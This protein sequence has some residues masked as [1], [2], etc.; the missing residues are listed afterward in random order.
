MTRVLV[1]GFD[2]FGGET[3]NPAWEAVDLLRN[4][5]YAGCRGGG[6]EIPGRVLD[7]HRD[8]KVAAV[9][10]TDPEYRRLRR[11]SRRIAAISRSNEWRSI[12]TMPEFGQ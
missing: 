11:T 4:R 1:T 2:P 5:N 10:D 12:L 8:V 6:R 7:V 3:V 9:P